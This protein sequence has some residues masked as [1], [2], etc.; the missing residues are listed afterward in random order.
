MHLPVDQAI[1]SSPF[2]DWTRSS[3]RDATGGLSL[4]YQSQ[5]RTH[6]LLWSGFLSTIHDFQ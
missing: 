6:N 2:A 4:L 1:D 3:V 5:T